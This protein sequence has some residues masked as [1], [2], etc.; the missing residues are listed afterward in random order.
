M[1]LVVQV[2]TT[3]VPSSRS[4][5]LMINFASGKDAFESSGGT[6]PCLRFAQD[7]CFAV[8][9][10]ALLCERYTIP[11]PLLTP[12]TESQRYFFS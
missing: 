2:I 12:W 6:K 9:A 1:M 4:A 5:P 3:C 10:C 7:S 8:M 11:S